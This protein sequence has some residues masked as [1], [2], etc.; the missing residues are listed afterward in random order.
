MDNTT[1]KSVIDAIAMAFSTTK[2]KQGNKEMHELD[3][4][5]N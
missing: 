3:R 4:K 1:K 5:E 2:K